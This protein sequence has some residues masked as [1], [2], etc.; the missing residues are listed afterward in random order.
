MSEYLVENISRT[1]EQLTHRLDLPTPT[2]E[3][4]NILAGAKKDEKGNSGDNIKYATITKTTSREHSHFSKVRITEPTNLDSETRTLLKT[5][6]IK[7]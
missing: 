4:Y 3:N 7:M 5:H 1:L 6:S 2:S